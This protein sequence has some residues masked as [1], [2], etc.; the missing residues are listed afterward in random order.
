MY[1]VSPEFKAKMAANEQMFAKVQIDFT[2]PSMDQSIVAVA[3]EQGN[4]SPLKQ[5]ADGLTEPAAKYIGSDGAWII[6]GTWG[7]APGA[8][9]SAQMGWW[10]TQLSDGSGDFSVPFPSLSVSFR[11]RPLHSL[12]VVGDRLRE[13]YPVNF[14]VKLYDKEDVELHT[15]TVTGNNAVDWE[16]AIEP[17]PD[18][19]KV[20][21]TIT[22]WSHAGRQAKILEFFTS[23]QELYLDDELI[24]MDILEEREVGHGSSPIGNIS[25]N[26]LR[27]KLVN[28]NGKFDMSNPLSPLYKMLKPNRRVRAWAGYDTGKLLLDERVYDQIALTDDF[29]QG[30]LTDVIEDEGDLRLE[31]GVAPGPQTLVGGNSDAG[32]YGEV[33]ASEFITGDALCSLIGLSAGTSQNSNTNWLKFSYQ[34]K[35]QYVAK[36]SIRR[37]I[38]WDELNAAGCVFGTATVEIGGITYKVR[39]MRGALT[40]PAA[41]G[42]TDRG[43]KGSEWNKLMLPIHVGAPSTWGSPN[44]VES[45][46][47]DWNVNMTNAD[48]GIVG[49]NLDG[50]FTLCQETLQTDSNSVTGRGHTD[51]SHANYAQKNVRWNGG[52]FRPVLEAISDGY[53]PTGTRISAPIPLNGINTVE[54]AIIV[55][56][57][58][59]PPGTSITVETGISDSEEQEPSEYTP[60]SS[61]SRVP[62]LQGDVSGKFLWLRQTLSTN[63]DT[64]TPVLNPPQITLDVVTGEVS[65]IDA[66]EGE[67][68]YVPLGVYWTN[69]W[70]APQN[71]KYVDITCYDRLERLRGSDYTT[72]VVKENVTLYDLA[73]D[74]FQDAGLSEGEYFIDLSLKGI[75]V[76]YAYF[77][78]QPHKEALRLIAE[79][80]LGQVYCDRDG[81]IRVEGSGY[82]YRGESALTIDEYFS[83]NTPARH[84]EII[85]SIE[86]ETQ[87]LVVSGIEEVYKSNSLETIKAETVT[88][89]VNFNSAPCV[90]AL[91]SLEGETEGCEIVDAQYYAWGAVI[92]ITNPTPGSFTMVV[93]AK[94]LKVM[95]KRRITVEDEESIKEH[96]K[97]IYRFPANPLVQT[98]SAARL[99]AESL[100]GNY[101]EAQKDTD[102]E[103]PGN[104][105]LLIADR[106]TVVDN[107]GET[108]YYVIRQELSYNGG[109]RSSLTGR[110]V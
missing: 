7:I 60:V 101:K 107:Y 19:A 2:S 63:D 56:S 21:L 66:P 37:Y 74:V 104:L 11:P 91:A 12:T 81:V 13:E 96:L 23:I 4:L 55:Y 50:D 47:E 76:P 10:G 80:S 41:Y 75:Y 58:L 72:S 98:T 97:Q 16:T 92:T 40:D 94:P 79:A 88:L 29:E 48:L 15:E 35:V 32:Y 57:S 51:V 3:S 49:T 100:I 61:G 99:I 20:E 89:T 30:I 26:E 102:I 6:D 95:N 65:F 22:K 31:G 84:N 77:E 64:V 18:V 108:E 43:C 45:P 14:T 71:K 68:E 44:Y 54:S 59:T 90:E 70:D 27:F 53:P 24:S 25:S 34:G 46:T 69:T 5:T 1:P 9:E 33:T 85:N 105:A 93:N 36:K 38:R 78:P 67:Y 8:S 82:L 39:C 52:G 62:R 86:V 103:W 17:V 42:D 28:E 83:R 110:K 106:I 109:L 73:L 87:P